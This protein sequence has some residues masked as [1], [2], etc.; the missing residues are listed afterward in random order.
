ML[1]GVIEPLRLFWCQIY[2]TVIQ[3]TTRHFTPCLVVNC[4]SMKGWGTHLDWKLLVK[5][6]EYRLK[7]KA[8]DKSPQ[9][10]IVCPLA[11]SYWFWVLYVN[12][13]HQ[14][15]NN[16]VMF[17]NK[18]KLHGGIWV[19]CNN[20]TLLTTSSIIQ[21]FTFWKTFS[22]VVATSMQHLMPQ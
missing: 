12:N 9:I 13:Q 18:Q 6:Q 20:F 4:K 7:S 16:A 15:I 2:A 22:T 3:F 8:I 10:F 11:V 17:T 5:K 1:S 14:C 21:L 19:T